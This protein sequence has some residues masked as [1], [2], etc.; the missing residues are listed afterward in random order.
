MRKPNMRVL[1]AILAVVLAGL[2][3]ASLVVWT[4]GARDRAFSGV[5][6]VTVWQVTKEV[7][8]GTD[9]D[10][11]GDS[12]KQVSLPR[13][14]VPSTAL[15]SLDTVKGKTTTASLVPGEVLVAGRFG[16]LK[17]ATEIPV[18]NGMQEVTIEL[19][20]TRVLGGVLKRADQVGVVASY[21]TPVDGVTNFAVN[22][23]L[24]LA[25]TA[26]G[27]TTQ[28]GDAAAPPTGNLQVRLALAAADVEKVVHASEFGK[29][30]LARQNKDAKVG[31]NVI[32]A[33]E[34][35]R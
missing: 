8:V 9:A 7:P 26:V 18:P 2:G 5:E 24:V 35:V 15:T 10:A 21:G 14:G 20:S 3:I 31:R 6:T 29:V 27:T 1:V 4:N 25:V 22:R 32:T 19:A 30:W 13:V 28:T 12:V 23:V 11:I 17:D 34:V 33:E 16:S